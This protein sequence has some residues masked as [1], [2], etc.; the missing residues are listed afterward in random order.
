MRVKNSELYFLPYKE[1]YTLLFKNSRKEW[2][3]IDQDDVVTNVDEGREF[4]LKAR[5]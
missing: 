1:K 4:V 3:G 2:V 5:D